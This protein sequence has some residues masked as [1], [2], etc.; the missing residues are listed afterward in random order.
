MLEEVAEQIQDKLVKD[1][2]LVQDSSML[3]SWVIKPCG[4]VAI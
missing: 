2:K 3:A 4:L 1:E